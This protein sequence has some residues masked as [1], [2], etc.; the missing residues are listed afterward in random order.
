MI[1]INKIIRSKRKTFALEI[2]DDARLII[3]S[4]KRASVKEIHKIMNKNKLWIRKKQEL[5]RQKYLKTKKKEFVN[6]EEFLYLGEV[7]ILFMV[8]NPEIPL[9]NKNKTF[10]LARECIDN[11]R[12]VFIQWYKEQAFR[13]ISERAAWYS[14]ISGLRYNKVSI[15][16]AHK[17]W[18]SCSPK[19]N[20]NFSMRLIMA[21]LRVIDYVVVH[22]IA[23]IEEKNH[24]KRFWNK[25]KTMLPDYA[26]RKKWLNE[27]GY[28][29]FI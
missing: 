6:S 17:R 20:L 1:E 10:M 27:N 23:H 29:L 24:S 21:P 22:E 2:S 16:N 18:G 7:Y 12:E 9:T 13:I 15:T 11:A 19:E 4:P 8:D 14:S 5:A 25:V 26:Q 3:R 28:L